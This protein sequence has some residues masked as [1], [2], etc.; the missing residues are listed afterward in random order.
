LSSSLLGTSRN[1]LG[2]DAFHHIFELLYRIVSKHR[3]TFLKSS[4]SKTTRGTAA[5]RLE[6]AAAALRLTVEAVVSKIKFKTALSVLDHIVDTLPLTDGSLCE[7]IKHDYLRSFRTVLDYAPH[8]EHMRPRQWQAYVD[9]ALGCLSTVLEDAADQ[10][11]SVGSREPSLAPRNDLSLSLRHSQRSSRSIGKDQATL[12]EETVSALKSLT[13]ITNARTMTRAKA[14]AEKLYTFLGIASSGQED[15]FATFNNILLLTTAQDV[16]FTQIC[17]GELT[18]V[19]R[20][21]WSQSSRSNALREQML[22]TLFIC[23]HLFMASKGPWPV[24]SVDLLEPLLAKLSGDYCSRTEKE[25]MHFEDMQPLLISDN[26]PLQLKHFKPLRKSSR[27]VNCWLTLDVVATLMVG[28]SRRQHQSHSLTDEEELPRKRRKVQ[29]HLSEIVERA[30]T[31]TGPEK[32]AALQVS[33]FVLEHL[34]ANETESLRLERLAP[35]LL[36]ENSSIQTWT[37]LVYARLAEIVSNTAQQADVWT[38]TW[39][40]ARRAMTITST[41]RASCHVLTVLLRTRALGAALSRSLI[42]DTLF[43]SGNNGPST[44]TDTSLIFATE[45]LQSD[46]FENDR[47]FENLCLNLLGWLSARWTLRGLHFAWMLENMLTCNQLQALTDFTTP[48]WLHTPAQTCFTL[49]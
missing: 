31:A 22:I 6:V 26:C 33:L 19:I 37:F 47:L 40:A 11:H 38:R 29:T 43:G 20:R 2:D 13:A 23:R 30:I 3:P 39:D 9:F 4:A 36:H 21:L 27:A 44:L 14:I 49:H 41:A 18:P 8:G 15:A 42:D 34:S 16:A 35:D 17:V 32:L 28:L 46:M 7:P 1:I 25:M 10:D 5:S 12:A 24:L 45:V 48:P